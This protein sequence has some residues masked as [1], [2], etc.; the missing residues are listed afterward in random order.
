GAG[1]PPVEF[2]DFI[3]HRPGTAYPNF[4]GARPAGSAAVGWIRAA[5]LLAR[6]GDAFGGACRAASSTPGPQPGRRAPAVTPGAGV[7]GAEG[8]ETFSSRP[9]TCGQFFAH[10]LPAR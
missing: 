7:S 6:G 5:V 10:A 2:E 8:R 1:K 9:F 3:H 4:Q